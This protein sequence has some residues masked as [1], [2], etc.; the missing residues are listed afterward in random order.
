MVGDGGGASARNA[1]SILGAVAPFV[2]HALGVVLLFLVICSLVLHSP[3]VSVEVVVAV[4]L[5]RVVVVVGW[6][7]LV[8][9]WGCLLRKGL[10]WLWLRYVCW[11]WS[12]V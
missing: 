8:L 12:W 3:L 7:A 5:V 4:V 9:D 10:Q 11:G 6:V 1:F 2:A